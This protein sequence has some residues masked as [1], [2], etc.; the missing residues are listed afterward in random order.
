MTS[1]LHKRALS[2]IAE[3]KIRRRACGPNSRQ[4]AR[5]SRARLVFQIFLDSPENRVR[6]GA[7]PIHPLFFDPALAQGHVR[8]KRDGPHHGGVDAAYDAALCIGRLYQVP[9]LE[10][11][12]DPH[13]CQHSTFWA[14]MRQR[15]SRRCVKKRITSVNGAHGIE[16]HLVVKT[17]NIDRNFEANKH[18]L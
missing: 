5:G 9:D 18:V 6:Y 15:D 3:K 1:C 7:L 13:I 17:R 12:V 16:K 2:D 10:A 11:R 14:A 4:L 8:H